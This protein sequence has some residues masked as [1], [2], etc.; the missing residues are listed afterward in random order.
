M[1]RQTRLPYAKCIFRTDR[2]LT[3]ISFFVRPEGLEPPTL[4]IE[5]SCSIQLSYRREDN[6][7]KIP[8]NKLK[9]NEN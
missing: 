6:K 4:T 5:A 3:C 1:F 7:I 2:N 9:F 8:Q